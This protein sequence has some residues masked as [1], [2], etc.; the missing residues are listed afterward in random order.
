MRFLRFALS[1]TAGIL[2]SLLG[3]ALSWGS[4]PPPVRPRLL[5]LLIVDQLP[6]LSWERTSPLFQG[7]LRWLEDPQTSFR[8]TLRYA[9]AIT[10]TGPG[11]ATL[12]TGAGPDVHGI[13]GNKWWEGGVRRGCDS[14]PDAL[15]GTET[16]A[17]SVQVG[18]GKVVALSLKSRSARFLGGPNADLAAWINDETGRFVVDRPGSSLPS[19]RPPPAWLESLSDTLPERSGRPW[20]LLKEPAIYRQATGQEDDVPWESPWRGMTR[21]FPHLDFEPQAARA[22]QEKGSID[23]WEPFFSRPEAGSLLVD[24]AL[25]AVDA[26]ELGKDGSPDLLAISFSHID[27]IG[28]TFTPGSWEYL[29]GLLRLDVDL[30][31]LWKGLQAR[32]GK[33]SWGTALSADHGAPQ[34]PLAWVAVDTLAARVEEALRSEFP[35]ISGLGEDRVRTEAPWM[36]LPARFAEEGA[37]RRRALALAREVLNAAPGLRDVVTV[38]RP[39]SAGGGIDPSLPF[40]KEVALSFHPRRGGD[41]FLVAE[42]QTCF[43]K[44]H[45]RG[46]YGVEHGNPYSDDARV[47][48]RLRGPGLVP[49]LLTEEGDPRQ[50]ASTLARWMGWGVPAR[51]ARPGPLERALPPS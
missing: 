27:Y 25:E 6:V 28:H 41:L 20:E 10:A 39:T 3:T 12:S 30:D 50:L 1:L 16:L 15:L 51:A 31:R 49:G 24:A 47:P 40:G 7:G 4:P 19:T 29:D 43:L 38:P 33:D 42:P 36:W 22:A 11:H 32:R 13:T 34:R 37:E 21:A 18:R 35:A 44:E 2:P 46:A 14:V 48:L 45:D 5:V 9:H 17:H 26:L 23:A 8:G